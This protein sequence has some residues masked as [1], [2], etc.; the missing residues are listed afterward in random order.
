MMKVR[1]VLPQPFR[2]RELFVSIRA[3]GKLPKLKW[4][5]CAPCP[6]KRTEAGGAKIESQFFVIGGYQTL[7]QVLSTVDVFDLESKRWVD[8][9]AMPADVPQTHAGVACDGEQFIYLAGGQLG[10]QCRP[11]VSDC[12]MLDVR[13]RSWSRFPSLPEPRYA[14]AMRLWH[15]RLHVISGAKPDRWTS[16]FD[17]WSIGV[18]GGR[19]MENHW[20]EEDPI[21]KG[22]PHRASAICDD[23]LCILGGQD[24]DQRPFPQDVSYRCN[25]ATPLE[26][27]YG[28]AF[29][30]RVETDQ[31]KS[32]SAMPHP[33]THCEGIAI[34]QYALIVGGNEGRHRLANL[35]Q[36]YDV[37]A[38]S[39]RSVARLPYRMKTTSVYHEGW[40]FLVTGQRS[41]N[42]VNPVPGEVT[43]KV[44]CA[45]FDPQ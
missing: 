37:R 21:P 9:I 18:S 31:W 35:I 15:G 27:L 5:E 6:D 40:L 10:P 16:A 24:G 13:A 34:G 8:R 14:P 17:H 30:K 36:L 41:K 43:N 20:R 28:E 23:A 33:Q 42:M 32:I 39:W 25:S 45:R 12:F 38:N 11:S 7:D 44:W 3:A 22:G 4:E 19:P 29:I 26:T 2:L 1:S